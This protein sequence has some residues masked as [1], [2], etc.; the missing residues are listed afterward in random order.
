MQ[1]VVELDCGHKYCKECYLKHKS[2][3]KQPSCPLCKRVF[4]RRSA[5]YTDNYASTLGKFVYNCCKN[6]KG[7]YKCE[8]NSKYY[9]INISS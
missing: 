1:D 2:T 8:G 5:I 4:K 6:I 3:Q 7:I 9:S